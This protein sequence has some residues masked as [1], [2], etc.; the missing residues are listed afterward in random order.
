MIASLEILLSMRL[1]VVVFRSERLP[2]AAGVGAAA[3]AALRPPGR[4]LIFA[5]ALPAQNALGRH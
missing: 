3:L 1:L 2:G 5:R 4:R